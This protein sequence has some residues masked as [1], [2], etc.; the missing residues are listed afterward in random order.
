M[1]TTPEQRLDWLQAQARAFMQSPVNDLQMP[2]PE[3]AF[4]LPLLGVAAG[5]DALWTTYK[6]AV[7]PFHWTPAEAF[8]L[9]F[10][11]QLVTPAELRV[12]VW[13][14]PQTEATR[15]DNAKENHTPSERWARNRT[16]S[17]NRVNDG[18]RRFMVEAL[19]EQGIFA[20]APILM[21]EW[22]GK[23]VGVYG[24]SSNW[25]ERH[26]AHVAGLG[27]FGLSDGLITPRGK[28]VRLGSLV[29]RC[30]LPVTERPYTHYREYC[31]YFTKGTCRQCVDRCPV[32]SVRCEGRIK[33][34]C[35]Q[36]AYG[37][38]SRFIKDRWNLDG[39]CCGLCQTNV[40]CEA[41]IPGLRTY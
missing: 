18:L 26:A 41:G 15:R 38:C 36:H 1:D 32:G 12:L 23:E 19:Q 37:E 21:P 20:T 4:D 17:E 3:P 28:A 10:P 24:Y 30:A 8:A 25:S 7:G 14:L 2:E 11:G 13:V 33:A 34:L 31:L 9:A 40:P 29:A 35:K 6:S 39:D 16:L 22:S 5:D 27:T